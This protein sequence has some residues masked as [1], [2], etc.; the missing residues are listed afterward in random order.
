M[1]LTY[2][3]AEHILVVIN[4]IQNNG[5]TVVMVLEVRAEFLLK[6]G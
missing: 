1:V 6:N 5:I 3:K 2:E 4:I